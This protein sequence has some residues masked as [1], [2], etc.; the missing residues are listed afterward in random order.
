MNKA[1]VSICIA[2]YNV[3]KYIEQCVRS[4][5]E[6]TLDDLEYV[7]VDDASPDASIDVMLRV[8]EEYPHRK[9]Q[10]KLIRH[11]HNQGVAVTRKDA[12]AAATGEYI[13]HCDP[14][15]W[16]ELDMYEKL[17]K[18]A[19]E[20]NADMV[21]CSFFKSGETEV[22]VEEFEFATSKEMIRAFF[23]AQSHCSLWNKLYDSKIIKEMNWELPPEINM[24]E[25]FRLNVQLLLHCSKIVLYP[26]ALYH[27]RTNDKSLTTGLRSE[28]SF[29][30]EISNVSFFEQ[31]L[32]E[33][34][35][36]DA[37]DNYKQRTLMEGL[38][39]AG[40]PAPLWH[41]L[42]K[43]AKYKLFFRKG[44][45]VKLKCIFYLACINYPFAVW[46]WRK[47]REWKK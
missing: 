10:V 3:E 8:L 29:L 20:S 30:A 19:V 2:V 28:K 41:S 12:I 9:N 13:I 39:F 22:L 34:I 42:W 31:V 25:D 1:K 36:E 4:L 32:P 11:E 46:L 7:F 16:G 15:D 47:S 40:I 38:M 21:Y 5:F 35:F 26:Q 17:Y 23:I 27:Y 14:D 37:I 6:Q 45:P 33:K 44:Y 24:C 18:K 43:K